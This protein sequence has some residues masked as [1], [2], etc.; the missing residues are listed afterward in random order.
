M[1]YEILFS[2]AYMDGNLN[3]GVTRLTPRE[4]EIIELLLMG[5]DIREISEH[6]NIAPRTVKAHLG[7][8]YLRFGIAGGVKRVK[9]VAVFLSERLTQAEQVHAP[10]N[11]QDRKQ[12]VI[13]LV[14]QG[15]NNREM[16][17][18]MGIPEGVIKNDLKSIYDS[19]G[20]WNRLE[21]ALWYDGHQNPEL[22]I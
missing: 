15:L 19:L 22:A 13:K 18:A 1:F 6:L 11:A 10:V 4:R 21:L 2:G 7:R 5:C 3:G 8:I 17:V 20:V 12:Q 9:L 14:A 16:A